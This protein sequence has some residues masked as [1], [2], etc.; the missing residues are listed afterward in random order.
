MSEEPRF[1]DVFVDPNPNAPEGCGLR[2]KAERR[3]GPVRRLLLD[4][5]WHEVTG[6][7]SADGGSGCPAQAALVEDSGAG[8]AVLVFGGDWGIRLTPVDGGAPFG[9][10]HLLLDAAAL[11][12]PEPVTLEQLPLAHADAQALIARLD[13]ELTALYPEE[14]ANHFRLD[15]SEVAAGRGAFLVARRAGRAIGCGAVRLVPEGAELKRMFTLPDERGRGVGRAIVDELERVA[16]KLGAT[17]L[18]LETGVRQSEA[19]ALYARAGFVRIAPFGEYCSSPTS[20]CLA[21]VL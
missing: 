4:D 17:R 7:S 1:I 16:R 15:G 11:D 6:W 2:F 9:E 20:I 12:R 19:L 10:S 8:S 14:G 21:K 3:P 5:R 13:A 18:V